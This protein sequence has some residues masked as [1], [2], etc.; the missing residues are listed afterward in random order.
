MDA[1]RG[2]GIAGEAADAAATWHWMSPPVMGSAAFLWG[3]RGSLSAGGEMRLLSRLA[4]AS[5]FS[6]GGLMALRR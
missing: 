2:G 3:V 1:R 6:G 4:S 5:L